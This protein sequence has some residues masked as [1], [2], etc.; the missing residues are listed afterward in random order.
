MVRVAPTSSWSW[1][2]AR[3]SVHIAKARSLLSAAALA[4]CLASAAT[5]H[6]Q[7]FVYV[8]TSG[9]GVSQYDAMGGALSPLV[10]PGAPLGPTEQPEGVAISPD[11]RSV[12]VTS[13]NDNSVYQYDIA[14]DGT[15]AAKTP[16]S[17]GDANRPFAVAVSPDGNSIYVNSPYSGYVYQYDVG[18]GGRL[19]PK[20]PAAVPGGGSFG[21]AVSPDGK[22][23]YATGCGG[24]CHYHVGAGGTLTAEASIS[25]GGVGI[26]ISPNGHYVYVASN[27]SVA[28]FA[29]GT[30]GTLVP[31]KPASVNTG[32]EPWQLVVNPSGKSVYMTSRD[33][34]IFQFGVGATGRLTPLRPASVG[35]SGTTDGIAIS[36]NGKSVYVTSTGALSAGM[37]FQYNVGSDGTLSPKTPDGVPSGNAPEGIA[38]TKPVLGDTTV[39]GTVDSNSAGKAEAFSTQAT[40]SDDINGLHLYVDSSS[41]AS[42]AVVGIYSDHNGNPDTLLDHGTISNLTPGSWNYVDISPLRVTAGQRYWIA[43]LSPKGGGTISFR[44][45]GGGGRSETSTQKI[46]TGLPPQWSATSTRSASAPL[47]AY[48]S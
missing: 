13:F 38:I 8:A 44:D 21:I 18:D 35:A 10:P 45:V 30:A 5:A 3:C 25:T 20:A 11:G 29:V 28:Q 2:Q 7:P 42:N 19:T 39:E 41:T 36:P 27:G 24:V 34:Q 31:M 32:G 40:Y 16:A 33:G 48:G 6:A 43:L 15:L 17:V 1:R 9:G 26:A 23:V 47:S 46:L 14:A 37:V 12:Y 22:Q 4:G